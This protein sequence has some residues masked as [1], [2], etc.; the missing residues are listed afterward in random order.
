MQR[1]DSL[2]GCGLVLRDSPASAATLG[3]LIAAPAGS[4]LAPFRGASHID[5]RPNS[6]SAGHLGLAPADVARKSLA[7]RNAFCDPRRSVTCAAVTLR[8]GFRTSRVARVRGRG[9]RDTRRWRSHGE[10]ARSQ[11]PRRRGCTRRVLGAMR[12]GRCVSSE[13]YAAGVPIR[14]G[15]VSTM[16]VTLAG[17][18]NDCWLTFE[19][20]EP[21]WPSSGTRRRRGFPAVGRGAG[22]PT[23]ATPPPATCRHPPPCR[24]RS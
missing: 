15:A 17:R 23:C 10:R 6:A 3:G 18:A 7:L 19:K 12:P 20:P 11:S 2:S 1:R 8:A 4:R 22:D 13:N 21:T 14:V 9:D 5:W 16:T 24:N